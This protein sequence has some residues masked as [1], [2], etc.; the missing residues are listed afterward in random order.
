MDQI[1]TFH[2]HFGALTFQ[3]RLKKLGDRAVMMPVPRALSASCGTCVRFT[4]D[5]IPAAMSD[6]DLDAVYAVEDAGGYRLLFQN[7]EE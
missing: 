2:T 3:R 7:E 5:F 1:A 6:E 4:L